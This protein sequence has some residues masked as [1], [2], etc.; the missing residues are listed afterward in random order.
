MRGQVV[1][2]EARAARAGIT[3]GTHHVVADVQVH[4]DEGARRRWRA[5]Q[6]A[7]GGENHAGWQAHGGAAHDWHALGL[8]RD[9][10]RLVDGRANRKAV[11]RRG[12]AEQ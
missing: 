7:A 5:R 9:E 2:F 8:G 4:V 6:H 3:G 1:R 11:G 12:A 10:Q